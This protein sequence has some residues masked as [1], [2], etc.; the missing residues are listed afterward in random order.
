MP[1]YQRNRQVVSDSNFRNT[2]A[3]EWYIVTDDGKRYDLPC[4]PWVYY[5]IKNTSRYMVMCEKKMYRVTGAEAKRLMAQSQT[6]RT[7]SL[8]DFV[9]SQLT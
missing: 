4:S 6:E 5:R 8:L 7:A 9:F 3:S 2:V 1:R